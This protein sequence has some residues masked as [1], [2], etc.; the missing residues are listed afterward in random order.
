VQRVPALKHRQVEELK[1]QSYHFGLFGRE[2]LLEA[3]HCQLGSVK[4]VNQ[5]GG[6]L[7]VGTGAYFRADLVVQVLVWSGQV[8]A[9][10]V[11][12]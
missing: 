2:S 6:L 11:V 4:Q 1:S 12:D 10:G 5:Y 8:Y 9:C 3:L 7:L